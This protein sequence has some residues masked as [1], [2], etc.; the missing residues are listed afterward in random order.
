MNG[1]IQVPYFEPRSTCSY[2]WPSEI[3][4]LSTLCISMISLPSRS[5]I[6]TFVDNGIPTVTNCCQHIINFDLK[7]IL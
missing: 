6:L 3:S 1:E 4:N 7:N 2:I 5:I